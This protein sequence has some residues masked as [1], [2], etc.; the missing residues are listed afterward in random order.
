MLRPFEVGADRVSR[1]FRDAYHWFDGLVSARSENERLRNENEQLRQQYVVS[2]ES[3]VKSDGSIAIESARSGIA[4]RGPT[5][6]R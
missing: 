1:P 3:D 6:A 4:V 2:F 5:R